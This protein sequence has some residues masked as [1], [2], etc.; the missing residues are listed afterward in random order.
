MAT[1]ATRVEDLRPACGDCRDTGTVRVLDN[2]GGLSSPAFVH[3]VCASCEAWPR[4]RCPVCRGRARAGVACSNCR[5]GWVWWAD[6]GCTAAKVSER[7][8][9]VRREV[10]EG[11]PAEERVVMVLKPNPDVL[12]RW[13][14][15][16]IAKVRD[17]ELVECPNCAGDGVIPRPWPSPDPDPVECPTCEQS[18]RVSPEDRDEWLGWQSGGEPA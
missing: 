1:H 16:E 11:C 7:C 8:A 17:A 6:C 15:E 2:P 5:R 18:G 3:D 4:H 13:V 10:A 9:R 12:R 14:A